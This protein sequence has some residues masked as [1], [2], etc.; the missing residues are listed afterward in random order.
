MLASWRVLLNRMLSFVMS[1]GDSIE[2][3]LRQLHALCE[4]QDQDAFLPLK[5]HEIA[6]DIPR[7]MLQFNRLVDD[8]VELARERDIVNTDRLNV[9]PRS[10]GYG[11]YL[12]LGSEDANIWA[13]AWFGIDYTL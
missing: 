13:G 9:T 8:V 11:R 10:H 2:A 3:D 7:R 5:L 1:S 12:R 6:L 4:Q